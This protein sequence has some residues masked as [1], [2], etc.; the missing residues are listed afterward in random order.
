[1]DLGLDVV[2]VSAFLR[3]GAIDAET[4]RAE[5]RAART[6]GDQTGEAKACVCVRPQGR[7]EVKV[8]A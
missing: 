7:S 6:C 3:E 2:I 1:M 5:D 8:A 4:P